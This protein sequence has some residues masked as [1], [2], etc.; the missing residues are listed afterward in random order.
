MME[1]SLEDYKRLLAAA[2][3]DD[4]IVWCET[5]GA[6]LDRDDPATCTADDFTGCWKV[7]TRRAEHDH[8]CRSY[9]CLQ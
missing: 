2:E 6:W 1:I 4:M 7:A 3:A 9:R 8:L 5:C